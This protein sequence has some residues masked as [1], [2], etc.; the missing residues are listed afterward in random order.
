MRPQLF[1]IV[2]LFV[3]NNLFAQEFKTDLSYKYMY[4]N[5][6]DKA[7]QTY[8]FSRPFISQKQPLFM[9][10]LN[11]SMSYIFKST[12]NLNHGINISYSYFRSS[13]ENVNSEN[14]LNLHFLNLGYMIHYENKEKIKGLY[15]DLIISAISSGVFRTVN[16]APLLYEETRSKAFG[17][18]GDLCLKLG[19]SLKIKSKNYLSP[20]VSFGYTPYLYSPNFEAVINQ[21]KGLASKNWTGIITSQI[22]LTFHIKKQTYNYTKI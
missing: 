20:F 2:L 17:I 3:C 14:I 19:Y 7:I 5:Q 1:V 16:G 13:A 6:W 11:T 12:K 10:G 8:N 4:V 21:T 22:G 15:T 18:G 9:H